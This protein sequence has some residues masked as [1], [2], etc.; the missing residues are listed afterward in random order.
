MDVKMGDGLGDE[1]DDKIGGQKRALLLATVAFAICFSI[2][3]SLAPLAPRF[4]AEFG[5]SATQVGLLVATPVLLG[6]LARVPLGMI[7]DSVGARAVFPLLLLF[8]ALPVALVAFARSFPALLA[9][10]LLLG[11]AGA[12]FAVGVPFVA[13]WFSAERQGFALGIYG[14][15]N[16]GTAVA[17][18][19]MP[20]LVDRVGQTWAFLGLVPVL[21]GAAAVFWVLGREAPGFQPNRASLADRTAVFRREPAAWVL[22]L[23]YFLTFGGFV[24][25]GL[26]L[27]TLLVSDYRLEPADAGA[28]AAGFVALATLA[29]PIGGYLADRVGGENILNGSFAVVALLAIILAFGPGMP[30]ITVAFLGIA[31]ALGLGNGA[32]FKLVPS[33]FSRDTGSVTGLVGAAGGLGGFFPPLLLGAVQDATG[34]HAIAFMLLS[35]I[36]LGCLIVNVLVLQRGARLFYRAEPGRR[37]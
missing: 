4:R 30:A 36:A 28:R 22:A 16:A 7:A 5:L 33:Y 11:I 12:S 9:A 2:W 34:S 23:F 19:A 37:E 13:R 14:L 8:S 29:R 1:M 35:E 17:A 27:P 15:G 3:G 26:Y 6:S 25:I 20:R 18:M 21:V 24:A 32:V 10:S 31:A